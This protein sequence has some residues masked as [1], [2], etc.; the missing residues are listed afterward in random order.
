MHE[1]EQAKKHF[2]AILEFDAN[3]KAAHNQVVICNAKI[4]EQREKDKKLYANIF[5]RMAEHDR[6]VS[7]QWRFGW[8]DEL[9]KGV[10]LDVDLEEV[11]REK[12]L[13][14]EEA[15]LARRKEHE[16]YLKRYGGKRAPPRP[17]GKDGKPLPL[18][19]EEE[20]EKPKADEESVSFV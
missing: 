9:G 8:W 7:G 10:Q 15:R 13:A 20:D 18:E 3:N 14:I 12:R 2:E 4:R 19:E 5:N 1:P 6:Q 11:D 17:L 16:D